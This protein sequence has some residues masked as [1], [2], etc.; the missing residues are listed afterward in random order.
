MPHYTHDKT[1]NPTLYTIKEIEGKGKGVVALVL[2]SEGTR[3][4]LEKPLFTCDKCNNSTTD[5]MIFRFP[6]MLI[7]YSTS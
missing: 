4:M 1:P 2:I 5:V 6:N 7:R 3:I